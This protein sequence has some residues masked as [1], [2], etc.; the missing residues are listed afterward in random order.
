M[1]ANHLII[2]EEHL[3]KWSQGFAYPA[4]PDIAAA[5][6][7]RLESEARPANLL[8]PRLAWGAAVVILL[9]G[10][11]LA[12]PPVR[13][14]VLE[15]LQIGAIR[16]FLTEPTP[17][18]TPGATQPPAQAGQAGNPTTPATPRP[19]PRPYP[20]LADL[21]GE[22]SLAE[23]QSQ[24]DFPILLP[25]YPPDLGEPDRVFLQDLGGQAVLLVWMDPEEPERIRLD[26]LLMGPGAFGEKFAPAVIAETNVNGKPAIWTEGPHTLNLGGMY[27]QVPLVV[28]G[29][30]LI[31]EEGEVTY[32][33]ETDLPLEEAVRI[34]GSLETIQTGEETSAT[35]EPPMT[36]TPSPTYLPLKSCPVT[37]PPDPPFT[38][39]PP[40]PSE[41][42]YEGE[43]WYGTEALWTMLGFDGAWRGLP[44]HGDHYVQKV[45]W[46]NEDYD[47]QAEPIPEF[48]V[49]LRRLD[50]PAPVFESTEATNAFADF[51][52]AILTG[53]EI[54]TLGC[55]QVTGS[56]RG[57][58]LSFVVQVEP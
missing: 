16:I 17:T 13:A 47:W 35:A 52:S 4:T 38:P 45:F 56:Y 48:K 5:V 7:L 8:R 32:R 33:L 39:P 21:P 6:A 44:D 14:Q 19:S 29:N 34:A 54:P 37:Q 24:L 43:F 27:Q 25:A 55:W 26:L 49:T 2:H 18:P 1:D 50:G 10:A 53:V 12:I 3:R 9:L 22:T 11:M 46:W 57:V 51:G 31:W 42:P 23:A 41:A 15:W 30:V 58:E 20:S 36:V 40:Y 28:Q